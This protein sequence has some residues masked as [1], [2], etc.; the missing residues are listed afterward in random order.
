MH[1]LDRRKAALLLFGGLSAMYLFCVPS[2][3]VRLAMAVS[4][5]PLS[6]M[7]CGIEDGFVYSSPERANILPFVK[8]QPYHTEQPPVDRPTAGELKNWA[9]YKVG[10]LCVAKYWGYC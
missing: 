2:G 4:G 5:H 6:A 7:S 9:V 3:A 8:L 10:P 1:T